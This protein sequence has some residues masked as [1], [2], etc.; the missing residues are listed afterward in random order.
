MD[1][2]STKTDSIGLNSACTIKIFDF[3]FNAKKNACK[4][5]FNKT[6]NK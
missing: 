2:E 4:I 6:N 3:E 5:K 1:N